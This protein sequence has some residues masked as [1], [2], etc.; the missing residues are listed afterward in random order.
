MC[1]LRRRAHQ[2][3][4]AALGLALSGPVV[5]WDAP[6]QTPGCPH[7]GER[8]SSNTSRV[9][10][11]CN[12]EG[13]AVDIRCQPHNDVTLPQ[14]IPV[15]DP[16]MS[17]ARRGWLRAAVAA[18]G[19]LSCQYSRGRSSIVRMAY[20]TRA[21]PLCLRCGRADSMGAVSPPALPRVLPT[22]TGTLSRTHA[23]AVAKT[24][25]ANRPAQAATN[26]GRLSGG[27]VRAR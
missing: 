7:C 26:P 1:R 10:N 18:P 17:L 22:S 16:L 13:F 19:A 8:S 4:S 21:T 24:M 11:T 14:Y 5:G 23:S 6:D 12:R 25:I 3:S 9:T 27:S 20:I 15:R 2:N